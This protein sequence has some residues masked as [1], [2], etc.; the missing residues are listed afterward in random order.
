M[1]PSHANHTG[2]QPATAPPA[3]GTSVKER[4]AGLRSRPDDPVVLHYVPHFAMQEGRCCMTLCGQSLT[5]RTA[6]TRQA[7][8]DGGALVC[9][10]CEMERDRWDSR[11]RDP[12][13]PSFPLGAGLG[14]RSLMED[15]AGLTVCEAA[16][17]AGLDPGRLNHEL[18]CGSIPIGDVQ[19]LA[20]ACGTDMNEA[21]SW[22]NAGQKAI[23]LIRQE[24]RQNG[25][26]R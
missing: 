3:G 11:I 4:A 19:A 12:S 26:C 21:L 23:E 6:L 13:E 20:S 17:R 8:E 15:R 22:I 25:A 2:Q 10:M 9:P 1:N 18:N 16:E 24:D 7:K 14:L 5:V